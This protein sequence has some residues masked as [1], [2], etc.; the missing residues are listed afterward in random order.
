VEF[1]RKQLYNALYNLVNNAIPETPS[2]GQVILRTRALPQDNENSYEPMVL[3]QVQDMGCG[4][5]EHV[6]ARLFT[7]QAISTKEGGTG[8]GTRIVHGIVQRHGGTITVE[9]R[10]GEGSTFSIRLPLR[11][12]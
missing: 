2:G 9:S 4:I 3:I 11:Q 10:E 5:P 7:D 6:R 8:L 12:K 1:D